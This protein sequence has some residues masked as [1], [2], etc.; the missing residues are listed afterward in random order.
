V[1]WPA[2]TGPGPDLKSIF[3]R[4]LP[5]WVLWVV[6]LVLLALAFFAAQTYA[7]PPTYHETDFKL[8]VVKRIEVQ[9]VE[10]ET[11]RYVERLQVKVVR[12]TTPVVVVAADGGCETI[13]VATRETITDNSVTE[14]SGDRRT[15]EKTKVDEERKE[16]KREVTK[17]GGP[18]WRV[19][20]GVGAS[21]VKPL[22]TIAGPLTLNTCGDRRI[23]GPFWLGACFSTVGEFQVKAYLE[24]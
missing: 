10:V 13:G 1:N 21:I 24:L 23:L 3:T 12:E 19:S 14:V 22:L 8:T 16:E 17:S 7:N 20:L 11:V 6:L 5:P 4:P 18:Q 2:G 9:K 15:E